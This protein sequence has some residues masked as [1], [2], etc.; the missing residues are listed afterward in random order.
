MASRTSHGDA[1]IRQAPQ[2]T[3]GSPYALRS[4]QARQQGPGVHT[5]VTYRGPTPAKRV[6]AAFPPLLS[7]RAHNR[8][9]HL[10]L[11]TPFLNLYT[12]PSRSSPPSLRGRSRDEPP[13]P[14]LVTFAVASSSRYPCRAPPP[15]VTP[16]DFHVLNRL[17]HLTP[18]PKTT[19]KSLKIDELVPKKQG[20]GRVCENRE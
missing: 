5:Q 12:Q 17:L 20:K 2:C 19:T 10:D 3:A 15:I 7:T 1:G 13:L 4:T 8:Q 14:P 16:T 18:D 9:L 6:A 11:G